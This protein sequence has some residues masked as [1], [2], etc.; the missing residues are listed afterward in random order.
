VL[1]HSYLFSKKIEWRKIDLANN[2]IGDEG[3]IA[4]SEALHSAKVEEL[5]LANN[6]ISPKGALALKAVMESNTRLHTVRLSGN[7]ELVANASSAALFSASGF[8]FAE[9][10]FT[11]A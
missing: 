11:R 10:L 2:N 4:L 9:L 3:L 7:A 5:N 6:K 1:L 8:K